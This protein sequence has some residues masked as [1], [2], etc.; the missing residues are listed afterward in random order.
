MSVRAASRRWVFLAWIAVATGAV[1]LA[2]PYVRSVI[3]LPNDTVGYVAVARNWILGRGFVDP[4]LY[5]YY[6]PG[7]RPP[8]PAIVIRPPVVSALFALPLLLGS[9]LAGLGLAH[10]LWASAI[11]ASSLLVARRMLPLAAA[12]AFAAAVTWSPAWTYAS[13]RLLSEASAVGVLLLL[14]A[15]APAGLRSVRGALLLGALTLLGW[16]TRPNL[17]AF[18]PLFVFAACIDRGPRRALRSKPL[19]V[20]VGCFLILHSLVSLGVRWISGFP[21]YAHYGIMAETLSDGD[22]PR[23]QTRY[24]GVLSFALRHAA[25]ILEFERRNLTLAWDYAFLSPFYLHV[26]WLAIPGIAYG[27]VRGGGDFFPRRLVAVATIGFA[28][29]GLLTSWG[30]APSRYLLPAAV[31]AWLAA[32]V[33]LHDAAGW[34]WRR[35]GRGLAP[36]AVASWFPLVVVLGLVGMQ[37]GPAACAALASGSS[38]RAAPVVL[39]QRGREWDAVSRALC[40]RIDPDALVASPNPWN[41]LYWCGNAGYWIPP[42]LDDLAALDRYLDDKKPGYL[43]EYRRD[44]VLL[45]ET[46]PRLERAHT[47]GPVTLFRVRDAPSESRPWHSPG[48][49]A[50]LGP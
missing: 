33:F 14:L 4:I 40:A 34:A 21:P 39:L 50:E 25:E 31:C 11:G 36:E 12:T 13:T 19:W 42:D 49:L 8:L 23:Y 2:V 37:V 18:A 17:G 35:F 44:A 27:L 32:I 6:L 16:L 24:V 26:G 3:Q 43:V 41:L 47:H 30:F 10:A 1:L 5:S 45:F 28:A 20:Y 29:T 46:S 7:A 15:A 9:G 48:P 38:S 22:L